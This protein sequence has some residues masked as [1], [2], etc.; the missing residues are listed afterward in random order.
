MAEVIPNHKDDLAFGTGV[1]AHQIGGVD[2]RSCIGRHI[3]GRGDRPV[4]AVHQP[5]LAIDDGGRLDLAQG[6]R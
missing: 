6:E 5:G 3:P 4:A 1:I 2:T